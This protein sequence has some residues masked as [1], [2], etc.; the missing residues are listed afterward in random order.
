MPT[1]STPVLNIPVRRITGEETTLADHQGKVLLIVNVASKCGLTPQYEGLE[2]LYRSY[3][4]Q[5]FVI[6]G[7]PSNDFAGQ[8]RHG[9]KSRFPCQIRVWW[10]GD[11][12]HFVIVRPS[13]EVCCAQHHLSR[14]GSGLPF[15]HRRLALSM[16]GRQ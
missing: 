14:K 11:R 3:G 6:C 15:I 4:E 12:K 2:N 8:E 7:F 10:H 1:M 16:R 13:E 9:R 5:G